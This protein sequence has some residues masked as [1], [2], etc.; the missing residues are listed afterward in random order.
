MGEDVELWQRLMYVEIKL[1]PRGNL[2]LAHIEQAR[3]YAI[4]ASQWA[5]QPIVCLA[6]AFTGKQTV[7]YKAYVGPCARSATTTD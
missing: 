5:G 7:V 6:L 3:G 1:E 2:Q 4:S